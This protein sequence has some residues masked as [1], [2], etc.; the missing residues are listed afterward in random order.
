METKARRGSRAVGPVE[1]LH[2]PVLSSEPHGE[3]PVQIEASAIPDPTP[4]PPVY[5]PQAP[6]PPAGLGLGAPRDGVADFGRE[7]ISALV[8]SRRAVATGLEAMSEQ[9]AGLACSSIDT[10]ARTA[11]EML[12]VRTV[13][14]AIAV[15]ASFVRASFEN[16]IGGSAKFSELGAKL[17][18]DSS[19]LFLERLGSGGVELSRT[20]S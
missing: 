3:S 9:M 16:W 8:E 7:P 10:A 15:N 20:S 18:A 14:D 11:I 19:R 17:A 2:S 12:A 13:S 6:I 4:L 5:E 1:I